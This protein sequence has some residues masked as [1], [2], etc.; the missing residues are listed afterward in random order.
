MT[1]GLDWGTGRY[2]LVADELQP[3]AEAVVRTA[4]VGPGERV[5]DLGC[6]TGNAALLAAAAGAEVT[7]V[8]PAA[9]LLEVA[10][11]RAAGDGLSIDFREGE[12]ASIP[13]GD[14]SADAILSVFGVIFAADPAAA[15]AEMARVLAPGGRIVLT[16]WL[17]VGTNSE[18]IALAGRLVSGAIGAPPP[19]PRFAWHDLAALGALFAPHGLAV[20]AEQHQLAATGASPADYLDRQASSHPVVM[21]GMRVLA[22]H[23]I[24]GQARDQFLDILRRGNED[25]A[26]FRCTSHYVV[27]MATSG[28]RT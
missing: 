6:G 7:G 25:P 28:P 19:Q 17:P 16:A 20:T 18:L 21:A 23:G 27:A 14:G 3:A 24:D 5:L 13:A 15:A 10:R 26:G 12:A 22:Q 8:D 1:G 2:E 9:R 11:E 4:A